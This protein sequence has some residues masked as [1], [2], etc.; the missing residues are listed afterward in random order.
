[1]PLRLWLKDSERRPDPAP[2]QTDDR[3]PMLLG[4]VGWLAALITLLFFAGPMIEGGNRWWLLTCAIGVAL[5]LAGL[6]YAHLK[7]RRARR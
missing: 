6:V 7:R 1:M 5:G 4:T 3:A 2:V